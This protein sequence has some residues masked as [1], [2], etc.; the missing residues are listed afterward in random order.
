MAPSVKNP[1][2]AQETRIQ[3][4]IQEDPL[5]GSGNP[6]QYSCLGSS[7]D[8]G[9]WQATVHRVTRTRHNLVT[10]PQSRSKIPQHRARPMTCSSHTCLFY[11]IL[12]QKLMAFDQG[13]FSV[14]K[15]QGYRAAGGQRPVETT[16]SITEQFPGLNR[17]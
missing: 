14:N 4:L 11:G 5:E 13:S 1:P 17:I 7:V 2:A 10:Q 9:A 12:G 16:G 8:G 3:S 6:L 15:A